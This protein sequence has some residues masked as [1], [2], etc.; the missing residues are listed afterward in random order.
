MRLE[1]LEKAFHKGVY[2]EHLPPEPEI[3]NQKFRDYYNIGIDVKLICDE[4]RFIDVALKNLS[5]QLDIPLGDAKT[6]SSDYKIIYNAM[7]SQ[8]QKLGELTDRL[9][10][11]EQEHPELSR[12]IE[13]PA[14]KVVSTCRDIQLDFKRL[15]KPEG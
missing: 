3:L 10:K 6:Y 9:A 11:I 2:A 5:A 14:G 13:E 4:V 12:V 7:A 1:G 8:S 15:T